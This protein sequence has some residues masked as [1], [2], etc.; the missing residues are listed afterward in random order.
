MEKNIYKTDL[1]NIVIVLEKKLNIE[2]RRIEE[3]EKELNLLPDGKL[4]IIVKCGRRKYYMKDDKGE[5]S[6]RK[7]NPLIKQLARKAV[8]ETELA[9]RKLIGD[10]VNTAL[11]ELKNKMDRV[12]RRSGSLTMRRIKDDTIHTH[13]RQSE[14]PYKRDHLRYVTKGGIK[15]RSKSE[16]TIGNLLEEYGILYRYEPELIINGNT[17]YPDFVIYPGDGSIIVWEHLV[18]MDDARYNMQ[19]WSKS[20]EYR[21]A[22]YRFHTNLIFTYEEDIEA[23]EILQGI[24]LNRI[25]CRI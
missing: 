12:C 10:A 24:I 5:H 20:E 4:Y 22:G 19:A 21:K 16:R 25:L 11:T 2:Q 9:E 8:V 17:V 15:V 18:L 13:T 3:L 1:N 6:L 14:N 23:E 7:T